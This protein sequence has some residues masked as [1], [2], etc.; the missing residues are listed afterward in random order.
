MLPSVSPHKSGDEMFAPQCQAEPGW[1]Q[2]WSHFFPLLAFIATE[3]MLWTKQCFPGERCWWAACFR[4][5]ARKCFVPWSCDPEPNIWPGCFY[6]CCTTL[7][8]VSWDRWDGPWSS[9]KG[10]PCC[11]QDSL[12]WSWVWSV[13]RDSKN[14]CRWDSSSLHPACTGVTCLNSLT[15]NRRKQAHLE[16]SSSDLFWTT[17]L[18]RWTALQKGQL[19]SPY[20]RGF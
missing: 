9:P 10:F 7:T 14:P 11:K 13:Y 3:G 6:P 8:Q 4:G 15:V 16:G 17:A 5:P 2:V 12:I 18:I 19:F 1:Q 20:C